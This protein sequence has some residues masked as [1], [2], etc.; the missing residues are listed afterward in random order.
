MLIRKLLHPE[1]I[2]LFN[3]DHLK[4]IVVIESFK[5]ILLNT[6]LNIF[7]AS[8]V[9]TLFALYSGTSYAEDWGDWGKETNS[10]NG[11]A[12]LESTISDLESD[13]ENQREFERIAPLDAKEQAV[14][15]ALD[16]SSLSDYSEKKMTREPELPAGSLL[17]SLERLEQL[18]LLGAD[19]R[20]HELSSDINSPADLLRSI[21][22]STDAD[23]GLST[24]VAT[25][26]GISGSGLEGS[27]KIENLDGVKIIEIND[28]FFLLQGTGETLSAQGMDGIEIIELD[29]GR[30]SINGI[31]A[32]DGAFVIEGTEGSEVFEADDGSF[33][34]DE[35][36]D[37]D[38]IDDSFRD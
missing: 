8:L 2:T 37:L 13:E 38:V 16:N 20:L 17:E 12:D 11:S 32:S 36:E 19:G 15:R 35:P 24:E 31:N 30:F 18:Q 6:T 9:L 10:F 27:I 1:T 5:G 34:I 25:D 14:F 22:I 7:I 28:G 29:D 26:A 23:R 3:T 4:G 21:I 33:I